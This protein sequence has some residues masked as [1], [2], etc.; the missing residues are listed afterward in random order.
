MKRDTVLTIDAATNIDIGL[1]EGNA[2]LVQLTGNC[3]FDGT[4]DFES[5]VDGGTYTNTPYIQVR[6]AS[7]S[8][9]VAQITSFSS[10]T[11]YLILPPVTQVRINVGAPCTGDL[12]VVWREVKYDGPLADLTAPLEST[13][14]GV[15][16]LATTTIDLEQAAAS[17]NLFT[18]TS[19]DVIL[20]SLV[21]QMPN[22]DASDD[23]NLTSISIQTDDVTAGVIINSTDG[24]VA[25][26]TA[27][28]QL[29]WTG[30]LKIT[31]ATK[32]QLTIGGGAADAATVCNVIVEY[33]AITSGGTLA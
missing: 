22:V 17:Y 33:V 19:Q 18:G 20:K 30:A 21:F 1:S 31:V 14:A 2:V 10:V 5:T 7:P 9:S 25:N 28:A 26:L 27:E 8:K 3:S 16:Q 12:D 23:C 32:I 15:T 13:D 4:V 11:E 24:A 6:S 29:A